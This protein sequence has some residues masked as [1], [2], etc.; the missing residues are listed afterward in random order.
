MTGNPP[1]VEISPVIRATLDALRRK[2]RV[3]VWFRGLGVLGACVGGAFWISLAADWFFEP[4][5]AVRAVALLA[6]AVA[7]VFAFWSLIG[8]RLA[9][10]ISDSNL[11]MVLERRFPHFGDSL[12]TAVD[13]AE[14]GKAADEC[15]PQLLAVCCRQAEQS[16]VALRLAEVFDY[17]PMRRSLAAAAVLLLS[18]AV[19]AAAYP[20]L[21]AVWARRAIL[22]SDELWPRNCALEVEGFPG[23]V[24]KVAR[25]ADLELV[26]KARLDMPLT[27]DLVEVRYRGAGGLRKTMTRVGNA[28]P[29]QDEYQEYTYTFRGVLAPI[30]FDVV[31]GDAAIRGL[32]I[33]V[34]DNPTIVE[35]S[36]D[37]E[38]PKYMDRAPRSL[39]VAGPTQVPVGTAI[40]VQARSN[41]SLEWASVETVS[42]DAPKPAMRV[43][44]SAE[45]PRRF[46]FSIPPLARDAA[47]LLTL[48]DS[49]G[50]K[51][52]E[53]VRLV[54]SALEDR[55]PEVSVQL[56]GIGS[57]VTP[58]ATIPVSGR[59]E[60]DYGLAR[61]WFEYTVDEGD[62]KAQPI[63]APPGNA[64][65][66]NVAGAFDV[67]PLALKPGQKLA[68]CVK[69]EDRFNLGPGP[70]VGASDRWLLE[71]VTPEQLRTMLQSREL[72]LRQR[73]ESLIKDVEDARDSLARLDPAP[74]GAAWDRRSSS[75]AAATVFAEPAVG[76]PAGQRARAP[77][78]EPGEA[79]HAA[80]DQSPE[81]LA[82][83]RLLQVQ[84]AQQNGRKSAYETSGIAD[85]F[86]QIR[87]ELI[88]NRIDTEELKLRL[89]DGISKPLRRVADE[90]FP[91]WDRRLDRLQLAMAEPQASKE[92]LAL[93]RQQADAILAVMRQVLGRMIELE[94]FN[95]AVEML[96]SI[97]QSERALQDEIKRRRRDKLRELME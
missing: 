20:A 3:Y 90:M 70:N 69:A 65:Q 2:L 71:V 47:L 73:F 6:A 21:A 59:A 84:W 60:D 45:D 94:D 79:P 92:A 29:G 85:A 55:R 87:E 89:E 11:A 25:G 97:L 62:A 50:I 39:P 54:L 52:R 18:L 40:V 27:P 83:Q 15:D 49:D 16:M 56:R 46:A 7:A 63:G 44:P 95:E 93:A 48:F 38:F 75:A 10:R 19:F 43:R 41:K 72:V 33:D 32:H 76:P 34:V 36:L 12:L 37:C 17:R 23:G 82:A 51:S 31:G 96:K 8:R 26:V 5:R 78:A 22:L 64:T 61:I 91:E 74:A 30:V 1:R 53:P 9:A 28:Q 68:L 81:R 42:D 58:Q 13:L 14:S 57:A 88:N 66:H 77:L 4:D 86:A 80:P 67:R 35:M 24:A